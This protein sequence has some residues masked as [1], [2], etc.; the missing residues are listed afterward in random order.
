MP[1]IVITYGTFDLFHFGHL[2][3][4]RKAKSLG[5]ILIVALSTE[6]FNKTKG[7]ISVIPFV[8]RKEILEGLKCVDKVVQENCWEQKKSDIEK[9][10]IDVL[11]MGDD[12]TGAFDY[13]QPLCE[14]VY[15]A[16]TKNV[17]TSSIKKRIRNF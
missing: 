10:K 12:W 4:L 17:S 15:L 8:E 7:K 1:K 3:L 5:D 16:R 9:Y 2:R 14:V 13:L 11:A 6:E